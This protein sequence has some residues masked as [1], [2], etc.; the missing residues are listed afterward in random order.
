ME[1]PQETGSM[2][3]FNDGRRHGAKFEH[4]AGTEAAHSQAPPP[5]R[6]ARSQ[7]QMKGNS[8]STNSTTSTSEAAKVEVDIP[9]AHG[10][11]NV[12]GRETHFDEAQKRHTHNRD[13]HASGEAHL[14]DRVVI[15]MRVTNFHAKGRGLRVGAS[16]GG[17]GS[18]SFGIRHAEL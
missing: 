18:S 17:G 14:A 12:M 15:A 6:A 2:Y 8:N 3:C 5:S 1:W 9:H 11:N 10:V 13:F 7:L 4:V 16:A